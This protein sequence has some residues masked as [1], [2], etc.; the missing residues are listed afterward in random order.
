MRGTGETPVSADH[1]E[2]RQTVFEKHLLAVIRAPKSGL[3]LA[4]Y[5]AL[6]LG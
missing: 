3:H 5:G 1:G 6:F 2:A 4:A